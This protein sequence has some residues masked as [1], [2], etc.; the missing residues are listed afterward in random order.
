MRS[1][2]RRIDLFQAAQW[3]RLRGSGD[4]EQRKTNST[5]ESKLL[6]ISILDRYRAPR[7]HPKKSTVTN[8][9]VSW[10]GRGQ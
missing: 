4:E 8:R 10:Q 7:S 5:Q 9:A 3:R 1:A 6:G 2:T